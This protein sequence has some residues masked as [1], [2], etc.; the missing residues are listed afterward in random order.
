M[1]IKRVLKEIAINILKGNIKFDKKTVL[2][3]RRVKH[4]FKALS[5]KNIHNRKKFIL[6]MIE[7]LPTLLPFV[8][9]LLQDAGVLHPDDFG[10]IGK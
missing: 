3:L 6:E 1:G 2:Q 5:S 4:I 9:D 8:I 7:L 10:L